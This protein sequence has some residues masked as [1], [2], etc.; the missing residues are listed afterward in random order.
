MTSSEIAQTGAFTTRF[1]EEVMATEPSASFGTHPT[2]QIGIDPVQAG[3]LK[4]WKLTPV[5]W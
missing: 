5:Q 1:F 3:Y 4:N 2:R